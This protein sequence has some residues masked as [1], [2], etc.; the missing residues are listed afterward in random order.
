MLAHGYRKGDERLSLP[1]IGAEWSLLY[2][3]PLM[4]FRY[5]FLMQNL[6]KL[7]RVVVD[8]TNDILLSYSN[9]EILLVYRAWATMIQRPDKLYFN[10]C[11]NLSF[12]LLQLSKNFIQTFR[13]FIIIICLLNKIFLRKEYKNAFYLIISLLS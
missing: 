11:Y 8:Q 1:Q 4:Y 12:Q 6:P 3:L 7:S 9:F 10:V 13:I 2:S 5:I